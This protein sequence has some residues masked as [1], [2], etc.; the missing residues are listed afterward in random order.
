MRNSYTL[1]DYGNFVKGSSN[2][3]GSPFVQMMPLTD[4]NEAHS[5]FVK[6]R[7]NGVDTTGDPSQY[8]VP[9]SEGLKSP[10]S[11]KEKK[12]HLAEKVLSRW[13]Y[14]LMGSLVLFFGLVGL[15]VWKCCC[16]K[17]CS[18]LVLVISGQ[19]LYTWTIGHKRA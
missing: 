13:P 4:M 8:L 11:S 12:L 18:E 6:V 2:D 5:D 3:R 15:C 14:I 9:A 7:L 10:E 19:S 17:P 16:Q 1:I